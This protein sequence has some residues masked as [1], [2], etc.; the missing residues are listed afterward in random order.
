MTVHKNSL[1]AFEL[2]ESNGILNAREKAILKIRMENTGP[3]RDCDFLELFKPGSERT[4][5]VQPRIT[6]LIDKNI[7]IEGPPGRSPYSNVNVR[8]TILNPIH[9]PKQQMELL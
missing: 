8:T 6:A 4:V 1:S 2:L 3:L 7:F 5:L 9:E